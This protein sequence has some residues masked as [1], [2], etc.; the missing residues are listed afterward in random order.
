[1]IHSLS[2]LRN[3]FAQN[4]IDIKEF[5]GWCLKI[6]KDTWTLAHDVFYRNNEPTSAKEKVLL[7]MYRKSMNKAKTRKWKAISTRKVISPK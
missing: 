1:M 5:N 6:G 3:F 4:D 7:E 2:E